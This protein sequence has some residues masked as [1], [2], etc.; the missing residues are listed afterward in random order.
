[1]TVSPPTLQE[2][3]VSPL[4]PGSQYVASCSKYR[5][6]HCCFY[7]IFVLGQRVRNRWQLAYMLLRN[8][9]LR[10]L[11]WQAIQDKLTT[12]SHNTSP[13]LLEENQDTESPNK[14]EESGENVVMV[15]DEQTTISLKES[16]PLRLYG[17]ELDTLVPTQIN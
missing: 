17:L 5:I 14:D 1:M 3:T 9:S 10:P 16:P 6:N 7:C 11:R 15:G 2:E 13:L 12:V 4:N 8:P